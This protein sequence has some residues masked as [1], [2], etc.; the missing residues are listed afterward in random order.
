MAYI[1]GYVTKEERAI[2]ERRGWD[3]ENASKYNLVGDTPDHLIGTPSEEHE[4]VVIF[5]DTNLIDIMSGPDWDTSEQ[6][7]QP[8]E[9]SDP[10]L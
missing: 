1:A 3:V 6:T 7:D 10:S 4:V 5:V 2:L 9:V 8:A